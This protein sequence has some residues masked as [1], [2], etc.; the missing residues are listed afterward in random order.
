MLEREG[1]GGG[2]TEGECTVVVEGGSE[3]DA[4]VQ[5]DRQSSGCEIVP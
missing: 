2:G 4:G 3:S 1:G 5:E